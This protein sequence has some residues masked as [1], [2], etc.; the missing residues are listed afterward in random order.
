MGR[1]LGLLQGE[2]RAIPGCVQMFLLQ[3]LA[4]ELAVLRQ[5]DRL[6]TGTQDGHTSSLQPGRQ[7]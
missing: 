2:G 7:G 1:F 5:V 3:D 6:G 4:E